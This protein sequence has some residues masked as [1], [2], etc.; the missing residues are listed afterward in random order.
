M[1]RWKWIADPT[2]YTPLLE[3]PCCGVSF[4]PIV[5]HLFNYCPICSKR[6]HPPKNDYLEKEGE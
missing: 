3:C 6:I 5:M 1:K 4:H 2:T